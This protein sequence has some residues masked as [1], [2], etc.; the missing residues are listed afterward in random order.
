M[1]DTFTVDDIEIKNVTITPEDKQPENKMSEKESKDFLKN[2]KEY[3]GSF[4][5]KQ[6]LKQASKE[7][8][9][10]T[11][12]I[13]NNFFEKALGTVG[14]ILGVVVE[15]TRNAGHTL[16]KIIDTVLNG[17]IDIICNIAQALFRLVTLNKTIK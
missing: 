17:A 4:E 15:T 12:T 2:F 16:I 1:D 7:T 14:D 3:V 8:G 11:K 13:A 5:F 9:I 10:P 6:K